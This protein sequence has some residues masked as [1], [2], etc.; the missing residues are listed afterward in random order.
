MG[1]HKKDRTKQQQFMAIDYN[2]HRLAD[3][4]IT[5]AIVKEEQ[6][7]DVEFEGLVRTGMIV[8]EEGIR[9]LYCEGWG[10]GKPPVGELL[11]PMN[12]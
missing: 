10:R 4:Q 11:V 8:A 5:K 12:P 9:L 6:R 1:K 3:Q 2:A 7:Q